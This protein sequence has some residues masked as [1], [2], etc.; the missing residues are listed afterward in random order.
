MNMDFSSTPGN[1]SDRRHCLTLKMCSKLVIQILANPGQ[2]RLE[3]RGCSPGVGAASGDLALQVPPRGPHP[4]LAL[5]SRRHHHT[6]HLQLRSGVPRPGGRAAFCT[7]YLASAI[8]SRDL[9]LEDILTTHTGGQVC[10]GQLW[11]LRSGSIS[12][13]QW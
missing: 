1:W 8:Y 11:L 12:W 7:W 10:V 9:H 3:L 13:R 5:H 4:C 6:R 2:S